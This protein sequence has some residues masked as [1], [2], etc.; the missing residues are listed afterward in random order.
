M[1]GSAFGLLSLSISSRNSPEESNEFTVKF[2]C[3]TSTRELHRFF[4]RKLT[5]RSHS[6]YKTIYVPPQT[7]GLIPWFKKP[8]AVFFTDK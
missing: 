4:N 2:H 7:T 1:L 8:G 3:N 5:H 6:Q